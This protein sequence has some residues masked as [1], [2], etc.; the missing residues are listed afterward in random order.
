MMKDE[1]F[2]L[3]LCPALYALAPWFGAN[4][5]RVPVAY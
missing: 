5:G 4:G 3:S 2:I 1:G